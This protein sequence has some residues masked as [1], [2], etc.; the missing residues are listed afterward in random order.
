MSQEDRL[1]L[2]FEISPRAARRTYC[3]CTKL[4]LLLS[5]SLSLF[6]HSSS[7]AA[8]AAAAR[9]RANNILTLR[10]RPNNRKCAVHMQ[11]T[12]GNS[13]HKYTKAIRII[14]YPKVLMIETVARCTL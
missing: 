8:C 13:S 10:Y 12:H 11:H 9:G 7:S 3:T 5:L 14:S 4:T 1:T 6:C 2:S